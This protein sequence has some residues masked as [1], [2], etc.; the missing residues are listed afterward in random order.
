M[1]EVQAQIKVA[2]N[3][4]KMFLGLLFKV[5]GTLKGIFRLYFKGK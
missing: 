1:A 4:G 3:Q 2:N 5:E